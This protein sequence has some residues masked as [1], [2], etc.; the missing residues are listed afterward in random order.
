MAV[1]QAGKEIRPRDRARIG[2]RDVDLEL[3][4]DDE[5]AGQGKDDPLGVDD[6]G[7]CGEIHPRGIGRG[8]QRHRLTQG[9]CDQIGPRQHLEHAQNRPPRTGGQQGGPPFAPVRGGFGFGQKAQEIHLFA[10]LR[11]Q[12]K[13]HPRRRTDHQKGGARLDLFGLGARKSGPHVKVEPDQRQ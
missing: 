7:E 4:Q 6:L 12:G 8:G 10:D 2:V 11:D 3:G 5:D 1:R 13:H 9:Q